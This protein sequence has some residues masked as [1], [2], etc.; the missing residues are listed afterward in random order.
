[1]MLVALGNS[2]QALNVLIFFL[3][4]G[5]ILFSS[6]VYHME[7]LYCPDQKAFNSS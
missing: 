3:G 6:V 4:I 7:N 5:C 1:M 2:G